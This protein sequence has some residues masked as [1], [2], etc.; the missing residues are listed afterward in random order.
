MVACLG[1]AAVFVP[2]LGLFF[3]IGPVMVAALLLGVVTQGTKI[4]AD[5]IVQ[6]AVEDD[7]RGRVFALYDVLFNVA[8]VVAAAVTAL[9]LPPNGRSAAVVTGVALVYAVSAVLYARAAR[10]TPPHTN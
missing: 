5:T 7:Y 2:A 1:S 9:V 4:C 6:Y 10:R 8:F 3:A